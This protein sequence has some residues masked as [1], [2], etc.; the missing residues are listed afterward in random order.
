MGHG[1]SELFLGDGFRRGKL[2]GI[3]AMHE[4]FLDGHGHV[5]I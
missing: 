3:G 4:G 5:L 1:V 2:P